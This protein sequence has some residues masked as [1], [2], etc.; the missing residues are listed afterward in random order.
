MTASAPASPD[1]PA[2][3]R[4]STETWMLILK[5]YVEGATAPRLAEKWRVSQHAIRKRATQHKATKRDWGDQQAIAQA[6]AREAELEAA[7]R[8]SPE[9]RAARLFEAEADEP[10]GAGDPAVLARE[11]TLASGR[12]MRGSLWTEAKALA[13]LAES[14]A[15]LGERAAAAAARAEGGGDGSWRSLPLWTLLEVVLDPD[16]AVAERFS[17]LPDDE[18][19][20]DAEAKAVF[21]EQQLGAWRAVKTNLQELMFRAV[22]AEKALEAL[23]GTP[24]VGVTDVEIEAWARDWLGGP[25]SEAN[26]LE[27][28]RLGQWPWR[29]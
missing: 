20:P 4:L 5:E 7:R 10:V 9:G 29:G 8:D 23:G 12:A 22:Y 14:Y 27:R 26:Y 1:G 25:P 21:W 6:V 3:Y 19:D 13:G 11:A 24:R 2:H 18:A 15:R 16:G 17:R 28:T